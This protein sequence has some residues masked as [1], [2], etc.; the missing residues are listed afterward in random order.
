MNHDA[1]SHAICHTVTLAMTKAAI[2]ALIDGGVI[3]SHADGSTYLQTWETVE[4]A[5]REALRVA[6]WCEHGIGEGEYCRSCNEEYKRAAR[7]HHG[8]DQ[9]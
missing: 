4:T 2:Q 9:S 8:E 1:P 3:P 6:P 7:E 5:L